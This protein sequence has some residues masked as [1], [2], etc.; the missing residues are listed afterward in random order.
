M[1]AGRF[2]CAALPAYCNILEKKNPCTFSFRPPRAGPDLE[3]TKKLTPC[4]VPGPPVRFSK[5]QVGNLHSGDFFR[6]TLPARPDWDP[7]NDPGNDETPYK[8]CV[9][10][11]LNIL[12]TLTMTISELKCWRRIVES[13]PPTR[14]RPPL[15]SWKIY[16]SDLGFS[17]R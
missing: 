8:Y 12:G 14:F 5:P 9:L 17:E 10:K 11:F 1:E 13:D 2:F 15:R 16:S 6:S 3:N 4:T 7:K